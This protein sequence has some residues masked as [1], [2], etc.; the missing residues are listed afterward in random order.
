V[1]DFSMPPEHEHRGAGHQPAGCA[2]IR[3]EA[4]VA[5]LVRSNPSPELLAHLDACPPCRDEYLEL[6]ALPPLLDAARNVAGSIP[7]ATTLPSVHLLDRLLSQVARRRRR[8]RRHLF[9]A[10]ATAAAVV[11]IAVPA[12]RLMDRDD[13][14]GSALEPGQSITISASTSAGSF[15]GSGRNPLSGAGADVTIVPVGRASAVSVSVHGLP[16]GGR[17][18]MV[19]LHDAGHALRADSWVIPAQHDPPRQYVERVEVAAASIERVELMD[20][21]TGRRLVDVPIHRV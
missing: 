21:L 10:L 12:S 7:A 20:D 16:V 2:Q 11:A 17:C 14:H 18:R 6:A 13:G 4:A 19:V 1:T 3:E 15:A 9:I 8:R 5:L